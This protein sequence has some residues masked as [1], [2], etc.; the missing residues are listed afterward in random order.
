VGSGSELWADMLR[1]TGIVDFENIVVVVVTGLCTS[2]LEFLFI[3]WLTLVRKMAI[4]L[5]S[6]N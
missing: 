5:F 1:E 2:T 4:S 3:A 6:I